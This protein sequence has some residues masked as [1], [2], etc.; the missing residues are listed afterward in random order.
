MSDSKI[1]ADNAESESDVFEF[2]PGELGNFS[3]GALLSGTSPEAKIEN[4]VEP[5]IDQPAEEA[6]ERSPAF[7][8]LAAPK[9][10]KLERENRARL[11]MQTPNRLFFY[12]STGAN[13]FQTLGRAL[14]DQAS[15]YSLVL[16][17]ADLKRHTEE[18][19]QIEQ[20]GSW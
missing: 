19:H 9:L 15:N 2:V 3:S 13:P 6:V 8:E 14:H 4:Q 1:T 7:K 11:A 10:P 20:E 16:K 12:W 17:L 5:Q 18:I